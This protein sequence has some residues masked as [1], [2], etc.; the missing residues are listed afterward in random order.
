MIQD[1]TYGT[2]D[3]QYKDIKAEAGDLVICIRGQEI[4][5]HSSEKGFA[6][7]PEVSR[8]KEWHPD[9]QMWSAVMMRIFYTVKIS[10]MKKFWSGMC[11]S[12]SMNSAPDSICRC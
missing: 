8:V 6:K 7:L 3:N 4:L 10:F 12:C 9:W 1:L 11:V 5:L 2:F